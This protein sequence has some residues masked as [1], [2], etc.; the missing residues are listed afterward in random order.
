ME[1][2]EVTVKNNINMFYF[3]YINE[4][5]HLCDNLQQN[6]FQNPKIIFYNSVQ[7]PTQFLVYNIKCDVFFYQIQ[8]MFL[9]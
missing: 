4:L 7:T 2:N 8:M 6:N 3:I 1:Y 5:Y 9:I